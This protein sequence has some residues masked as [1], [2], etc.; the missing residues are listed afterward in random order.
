MVNLIVSLSIRICPNKF[1][2]VTMW[3]LV[4]KDEILKCC[5]FETWSF[6]EKEKITSRT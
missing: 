3:V 4:L 5:D 1:M 2:N 6:T